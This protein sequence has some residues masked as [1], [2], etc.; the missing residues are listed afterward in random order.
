MGA[1]RHRV[2]SNLGATRGVGRFARMQQHRVLP[3]WLPR[4]PH[5]QPRRRAAT[6]TTS[7]PGCS[8][9]VRHE[10]SCISCNSVGSPVGEVGRR[11]RA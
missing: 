2:D 8:V 3:D 11:K 1:A 9:H 4:R 7:M 6:A 5:R 10:F